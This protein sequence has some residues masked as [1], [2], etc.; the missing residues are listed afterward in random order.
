MFFFCWTVFAC[1]VGSLSWVLENK[2]IY[3]FRHMDMGTLICPQNPYIFIVKCFWGRGYGDIFVWKKT[4]YIYKKSYSFKLLK[5]IYI[6]LESA[7]NKQLSCQ[8]WYSYLYGK[9]VFPNDW[10][11]SKFPKTILFVYI[12]IYI[13]ICI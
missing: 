4:I 8:I 12:Y 11:M 6:Y 10:L 9:S 3:I 2:I 5:H 1:I 13:Y 7:F